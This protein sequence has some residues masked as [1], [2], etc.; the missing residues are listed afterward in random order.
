MALIGAAPG[1]TPSPAEVRGAVRAGHQR[2]LALVAALTDEGAREPSALPG[3]TRGHVLAHLGDL[4][5]ALDRQTRAALAGELVEVYDG[6]RAARDASIEE[7][8]RRPA[9]ALVA[10]LEVACR[11]L[12]AAWAPLAD[13]AWALPTR[14][15][16]QDL[17]AVLLCWWREVE[18][19]TSD[20]ALGPTPQHWTAALRVHLLDHLAAR[21]PRGTR[22]ELQERPGGRTWSS[23]TGHPVTVS[24]RLEDLAAWTA[25]RAVAGPL[26]SSTGQLPVLGPWP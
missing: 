17:R 8:A 16:D 10:D 23:G 18:V 22:L 4:A 21:A 1:R 24:G 7:G 19:H 13:D 14:Y 12:D 26:R 3:W 15:R 6:G 9:A 20:L 5:R 11:A 2:L 25:G